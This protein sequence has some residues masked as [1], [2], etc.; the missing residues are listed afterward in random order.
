VKN[1]HGAFCGIC[2]ITRYL[3]PTDRKGSQVVATCKRGRGET[4]RAYVS[5]D[6][7]MPPNER[8]DPCDSSCSAHYL[9]VEKLL[10][11]FGQPMKVLAVGHDHEAYFWVLNH[12]QEA[13]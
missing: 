9:A 10:P 12:A 7:N 4:W 3:G 11:K 2:I 13:E 6:D 1:Q 8:W 5:F